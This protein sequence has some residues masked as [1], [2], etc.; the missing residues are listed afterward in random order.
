MARALDARHP[1]AVR[2]ADVAWPVAV[3]G[4]DG[5]AL[6][7]RAQALLEKATLV[8]GG[9]RHLDALAPPGVERVELAGDLAPA[10]DRITHHDG[11]AAVLASG[12]PGFF[13]ILRALAARVAPERLDVEPAPS[14]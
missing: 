11:P 5:A 14:S 12:D 2:E 7:P 6:T 1:A 13:G 8:A 3:L 10:L 4:V 9:T